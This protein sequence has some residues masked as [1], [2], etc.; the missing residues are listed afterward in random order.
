[1]KSFDMNSRSRRDFIKAAGSIASGLIWCP[2]AF[3]EQRSITIKDVRIAK[4]IAIEA[5][6]GTIGKFPGG[7]AL[8]PKTLEAHLPKIRELLVGKNALDVTLAGETLWDTIY[9]G[10]AKLFGEGQDPLTG[11][12]ILNKPRRDRHTATGRVFIAFSTVDIA[13]WDLRGRILGKPA[14]QIIG[15]AHRERVPVYW[16]PGE[17]GTAP[18]EARPKAREAFERGYRSQK[19][20]FSKGAKDGAPGFKENVELVRELREE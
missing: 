2:P 10:K 1:M 15:P 13:L 4:G 16:R 5:D 3:A 6:D 18:S 9:P 14:S 11:E 17:V 19:W 7:L 8:N 20:Y 12:L